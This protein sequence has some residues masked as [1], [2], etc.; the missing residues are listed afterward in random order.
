MNQESDS[1]GAQRHVRDTVR[2]EAQD[3][4]FGL[5]GAVDG[6]LPR[7]LVERMIAHA[8]DCTECAD[9]LEMLRQLKDLVR[10]SCCEAAPSALRER[11]AVQCRSVEVTRSTAEGT[12]TV[13]VTSARWSGQV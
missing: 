8:E 5:E 6:E 12:T 7:E 10:R 2:K 9:E 1:T 13:Q 4:R 11:I 3:L